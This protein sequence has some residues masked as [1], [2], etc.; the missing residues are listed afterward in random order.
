MS[1]PMALTFFIFRFRLT[2]IRRPR[3]AGSSSARNRSRLVSRGTGARS[4]RVSFIPMTREVFMVRPSQE[5]HEAQLFSYH[6]GGEGRQRESAQIIDE[7]S[8]VYREHLR[9][10]RNA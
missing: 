9:L 5:L 8:P 4:L 2:N 10:L 7:R 3:A 6:D 1:K